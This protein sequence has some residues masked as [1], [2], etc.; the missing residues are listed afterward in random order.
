VRAAPLGDIA[1]SWI[2]F[3]LGWTFAGAIF[4]TELVIDFVF[5]FVLGIVFQYFTIAPMRGLGFGEGMAAALRADTLSLIAFEIGLFA[6]MAI[7]RFRIFGAEIDPTSPVHWFMMQIGMILGFLTSYPV[8][9]WLL[10]KGR[11]EAM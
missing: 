1:G 6:W 9:K 5:A 7:E 3:L 11:K 4:P 2:V 8:N 10:L